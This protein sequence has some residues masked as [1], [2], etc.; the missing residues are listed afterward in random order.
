MDSCATIASIPGSLETESRFLNRVCDTTLTSKRF[1]RLKIHAL[2]CSEHRIKSEFG[3]DNF[4]NGFSKA[5][6]QTRFRKL[7]LRWC[8]GSS[9]LVPGTKGTH[10]KSNRMKSN[11]SSPQIVQ[12]QSDLAPVLNT[13]LLGG[14]EDRKVREGAPEPSGS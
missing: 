2:C 9:V 3:H 14:A 6:S 8:Q 11:L 4:S 10:S 13:L 5:S 7:A 12:I 1:N